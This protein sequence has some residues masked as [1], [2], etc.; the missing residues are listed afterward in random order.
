MS[1]APVD[2]LGTL[3]GMAVENEPRKVQFGVFELDVRTGELRKSGT[4]VKLPDQPFQILRELV[5]DPGELVTRE[6]LQER[7]WAEETFVDFEHS[8]NAAIKKL[9]D[10]LGDSTRS[11][12]YIET[13]PKRGYRFI[14]PVE[15]LV[16]S[17]DSLQGWRTRLLVAGASAALVTLG[18]S[19][20][21][22][23]DPPRVQFVPKP[24]TFDVGSER[25][26]SLS[27]DGSRV[28]YSW[29]G[30]SPGTTDSDIFVKLI[31]ADSG[32]PQ[33]VTEGPASDW[34]PAW[35][36]DGN[37]IVFIRE[38]DPDAELM[39]FGG[40]YQLMVVPVLGGQ[41]KRL[42]RFAARGNLYTRPAWSPDGE[43]IA[44]AGQLDPDEPTLSNRILLYSFETG[45]TRTL[46]EDADAS[47]SR[48][49][50]SPDGRTLA[51]SGNYGEGPGMYALGLDEDLRV[52]SEPR[53]VLP[54]I[55]HVSWSPDGENLFYLQQTEQTGLWSVSAFGH[56]LPKFV[57]PTTRTRYEL[58]IASG[59]SGGLRAAVAVESGDRDIMRVS[60]RSADAPLRALLQTTR[61]EAK[62]A[63]SPDGSR[64]VF[65]SD[66][67]GEPGIWIGD[68]EGR[69]AS[70]LTET[71]DFESP[72]WSPDGRRIAFH[73]TM[74]SGN[75]V[76][77]ADADGSGRPV[78][79]VHGRRPGWSSD[80]AWVYYRSEEGG[81]PAIWRIPAE[82]GE[83]EEVV[84]IGPGMGQTIESSDGRTLYATKPDGVLK[85][86]LGGA[87]RPTGEPEVLPKDMRGIT[88]L[89]DEVYYCT[90]SEVRR[91]DSKTG[92]TEAVRRL[93]EDQ[94]SDCSVSPD[95][96]WLLYSRQVRIGHDLLLLDSVN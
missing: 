65:V 39:S 92:K 5:R 82:G 51:F 30:H 78:P 44:F 75:Q 14:A 16:E 61:I 89:E 56:A 50:F 22:E 41:P 85:I 23:S 73:R 32:E 62:P 63:Y 58:S 4:R 80:G 43:H 54:G 88:V 91:Y 18:L 6:Q 2:R 36:P 90:P 38:E 37:R 45:E 12:R 72:V 96:Q 8:L 74:S 70:L 48:P 76:F 55:A 71:G 28:A 93:E 94:A 52:E 77:L 59:P 19:L 66:R 40:P 29:I 83:R 67:S 47:N 49:A 69:N 31:D 84:R 81:E 57:W 9:R 95:G 64:I 20:W 13:L 53:L 42:A 60:L 25:L 46:M 26:P 34:W 10:A 87:G 68:A 79:L 15:A 1:K 3:Q 17:E 7:L 21:P 86:P 24:I 33:R 35:S 27:R 11:P